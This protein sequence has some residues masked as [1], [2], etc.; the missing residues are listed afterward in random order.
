MTPARARRLTFNL[1]ALEVAL[2]P[3]RLEAEAR[4]LEQVATL[5]QAATEIEHVQHALRIELPYA[6][7]IDASSFWRAQIQQDA[8]ELT[9]ARALAA[10]LRRWA[11][12]HRCR[13][14]RAN[15]AF[16]RRVVRHQPRPVRGG[17][18]VHVSLS[19]VPRARG[20]RRRRQRSSSARRRARARQPE[21]GGPSGKRDSNPS[22]RRA[23]EARA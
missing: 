1:R 13:V 10:I 17:S 14:S 9:A 19:R 3:E 16:T 18:G 6:L 21:P 2:S 4:Q 15:T 5:L 20:K 23:D 12:K 7:S 22:D 11:R 8:D